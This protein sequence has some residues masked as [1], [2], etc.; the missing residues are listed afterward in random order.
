MPSSSRYRWVTALTVMQFAVVVVWAALTGG[1]LS[2]SLAALA[3]AFSGLAW[4][5]CAANASGSQA[6]TERV[7]DWIEDIRAGRYANV[8]EQLE[9]VGEDTSLLV[10]RRLHGA[11]AE[12][13]TLLRKQLDDSERTLTIALRDKESMAAQPHAD[14]GVVAQT[15]D[16]VAALH[17]SLT[18]I[19]EF[20]EQ[21][22]VYAREAA[23]R[24]G[25]TDAAVGACSKEMSLL[26]EYYRHLSGVF[27]ELTS[28][29]GRIAHIV[30]SI[31]EIANQTNLLA[32]NAAIEAARAGETGRGFAVVADEVRK[33]AERAAQSSKEIGQ[34]AEGLQHTA[35]EASGGV[36]KAGTSAEEGF[37]Q[38]QTALNTMAEVKASQPVR[39]EVVRKAR[40]QM[41]EQM[42]ICK[43]L[44]ADL[45]QWEASPGKGR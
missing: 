30:T 21:A 22:G 26:V 7:R 12:Q 3:A 41:D 27:Q 45:S 9:R 28:Q 39:A 10:A 6:G 38:A 44:A 33:L 16:H 43:Q 42:A 5:R 20:T 31:Q 2:W 14:H 34:I 32:L 19:I 40:E 36:A 13:L 23:Q 1:A 15:Q 8:T 37:K 17:H 24:V 11:M 25:I 29:S 35:G 18:R 4:W